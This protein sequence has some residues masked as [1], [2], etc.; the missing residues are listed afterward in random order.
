MAEAEDLSFLS[1][2]LTEPVYLLAEPESFQE[3]PVPETEVPAEMS[4]PPLQ[5]NVA[6]QEK[7]VQPLPSFEGSNRKHLLIL[8][9]QEGGGAMASQDK[10]LLGKIL[11]AV[12]YSFEDVALCNWASL[13]SEAGN[14]LK[15]YESL[16]KIP[17][18][19]ILVFGDPPLSWS[20]THFFRKYHISQD[21]TGK[22]LL[23]ADEIHEIAQNKDLKVQLWNA[24]QKL[25]IQA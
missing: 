14:D 17:S 1:F 12:H 23:Q 7:E 18:E 13:N 21:E 11:Q 6:R 25:F 5:E 15:V 16:N 10:A 9:H 20:Y 3:A 4:A 8:F 2:F 19:T 24:L 22:S